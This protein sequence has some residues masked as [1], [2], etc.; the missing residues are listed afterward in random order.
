MLI[1]PVLGT[2]LIPEAVA[3]KRLAVRLFNAEVAPSVLVARKGWATKGFM[4][5]DAGSTH[6]RDCCVGE[7]VHTWSLEE[8]GDD[9]DPDSHPDRATDCFAPH[10]AL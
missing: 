7:L 3:S 10:L 9:N 1:E 4:K 2:A 5:A 6:V 8:E